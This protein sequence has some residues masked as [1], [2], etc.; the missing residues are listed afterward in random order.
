MTRE[1]KRGDQLR[2][3]ICGECGRLLCAGCGAHAVEVPAGAT[4]IPGR[5]FV[6]EDECGWSALAGHDPEALNAD[7]AAALKV[8]RDG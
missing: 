7:F 2:T 6:C 4:P 5:L 1:P 8:M 3:E